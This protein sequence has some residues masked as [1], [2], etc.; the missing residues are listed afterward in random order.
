VIYAIE[1]LT[2]TIPEEVGESFKHVVNVGDDCF[3]GKS[4]WNMLESWHAGH[5]AAS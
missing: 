3:L 4:G 2:E 5:H 1:D